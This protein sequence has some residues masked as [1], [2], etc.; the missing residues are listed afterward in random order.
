MGKKTANS[1][2]ETL[3]DYQARNTI[4]GTEMCDDAVA[5][6][7][8]LFEEMCAAIESLSE[9]QIKILVRKAFDKIGLVGVKDLKFGGCDQIE[10]KGGGFR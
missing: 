8:Q 5:D 7:W 2:E 3:E 1:Y 9:D 10:G 4:L 6:K